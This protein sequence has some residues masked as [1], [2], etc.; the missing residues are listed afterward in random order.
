[1][2]FPGA[3]PHGG[4]WVI[5]CAFLVDTGFTLVRVF[6]E[7]PHLPTGPAYQRLSPRAHFPLVIT[8]DAVIWHFR[9]R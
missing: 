7:P 3:D 4:C 2:A 1:M 8:G 6:G 9:S 5:L